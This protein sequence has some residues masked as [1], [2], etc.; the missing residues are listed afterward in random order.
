[1][2]TIA[3]VAED[4]MKLVPEASVKSRVVEAHVPV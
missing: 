1:V 2:K 3:P 4:S